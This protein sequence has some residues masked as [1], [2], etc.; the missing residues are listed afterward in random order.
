M[1][2]TL[3]SKIR[4]LAAASALALLAAAPAAAQTREPGALLRSGIWNGDVGSYGVPQALQVLPPQRWP[5][6]GWVKLDW[7]PHGL[8][9]SAVAAPTE[10][11][12][13]FLRSIAVQVQAA[14]QGDT[15]GAGT[16]TEVRVDDPE[17]MY[18]RTPGR[19]LRQGFVP[20]YRFRNGTRELRPLLDHRY[21]LMW[22]GT[23]FAFTVQNGLRTPA[24][25]P[26]GEGAVYTIE[27]GGETYRY[28]LPGHG[29]DSAIQAIADLDGDGKPDFFVSIGGPNSG[30]EAVMLSSQAKPGNNVPT[31]TLTAFGC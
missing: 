20:A 11:Q 22:Q 3:V 27:I 23:P 25:M 8:R 19:T 18:L 31:A 4:T 14:A 10:G 15:G 9:V 1:T 16:L 29:W 5:G 24:G 30:T 28:V 2:A 21:E 12:P 17:P 13:G 26:Y 7:E 6:E